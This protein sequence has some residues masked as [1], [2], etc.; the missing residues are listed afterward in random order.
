MQV[1]LK[2]LAKKDKYTI[3]RLFVDGVYVCD[4]LEDTDRGLIDSDS[5]EKIK[6]TKVYGK[7]AIPTGKY[8]LAMNIVSPKYSTVDFYA[9]NANGGRVPRLLNVKGWV[10][11]LIHTGNTVE[12]TLGCILVGYN[13]KVGILTDSKK[14]FKLLYQKLS[15][16]KKQIWLEII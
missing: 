9:R 11:V 16:T 12:D 4:T 2:R 13:T 6:S 1:T 8:K 7:T 10:G 14:A 3:G 5:I 15:S